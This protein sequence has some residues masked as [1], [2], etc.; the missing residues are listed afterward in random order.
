MQPRGH[1][2]SAVM[3]AVCLTMAHAGAMGQ[4]S[5]RTQLF[6]DVDAAR[7]R[8]KESNADVCAPTSFSKGLDAYIEAQNSYQR[9]RPIDEIQERIRSS[10]K[11]FNAA[12]EATRAANTLF[13]STLAARNDA[14]TAD[15]MRSSP[16]TW[17]KAEGL[18]RS[19]AMSLEEGNAR[20]ARDD[21]GEAQGLYRK[22]E[23]EAIKANFLAPARTLL[24]RASEMKAKTTAPQTLERAHKLLNL[25]EAMIQQNRYDNGEAR[26]LAEE[27][28]YEAAH[29]IYLHQL[30]TSMRKDGRDVEDA[31][32]QSETAIAKIGQAL[33]THVRFDS[34]FV[35]PVQ[36]IVNAA[37]TKD[38]TMAR[39]ADSLKLMESQTEILRQ[40]VA[41]L[42]TRA[43]LAGNADRE[44]QDEERRKHDQTVAL[45]SILF[46]SEDGVVLRDGNNV[47]LRIHGL[48]FGPGKTAIDPQFSGLLSK[49]A[50]AIR[51]FPN[52][53]LT[54]EG[55]TEAGGTE[56]VNLRISEGRA[57]AVAAYLRGFLSPSTPIVT[58]GYGS[59]RPL[60][61][62]D[63]MEGRARNRRIDI[64]IIP[65]WAIVRR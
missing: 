65:E 44:R 53:Q 11:Y 25:A 33:D 59:S 35:A 18:L 61:D 45:A 54:V 5:Y 19:A 62:N 41:T 37:R 13:A 34:G 21:A 50:R 14:M 49:I 58:Q 28:S 2:L 9:G 29:A 1:L 12:T 46:T 56:S 3:I 51:M 38:S 43:G 8:A 48:E 23:L 20:S 30:I 4:E 22:A 42:E 52:C 64:I 40:R 39:M 26:R 16:D 60:A 15:A 24:D 17:T 27:A 10:M 47:I 57:E 6:R 32:L 63:T 55:H 31:F 36:Q 7:A